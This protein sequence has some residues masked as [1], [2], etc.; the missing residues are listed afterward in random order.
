MIAQGIEGI[1]KKPGSLVRSTSRALAETC[2]PFGFSFFSFFLDKCF[3]TELP[4]IRAIWCGKWI[5]LV[6]RKNSLLG[7]SEKKNVEE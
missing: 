4:G 3:E 6:R 5:G 2:D 1:Q 7:L